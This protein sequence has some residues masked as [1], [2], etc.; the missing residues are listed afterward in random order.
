MATK[1]A[2][3]MRWARAQ[4]IDPA[5][6]VSFD[7]GQHHVPSQSYSGG[8]VVELAFDADHKLSAAVCS[9][10]DHGKMV[11]LKAQ[12]ERAGQPVHK[13]I[14][15]LHGIVVCKHVLAAAKKVVEDAKRA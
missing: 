6:I 2:L 7:K 5:R 1:T 11:V 14:P 12:L 9:C 10:P 4:K 15:V 8:Y 3:S 13:G